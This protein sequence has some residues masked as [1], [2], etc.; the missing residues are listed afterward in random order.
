M[1]AFPL[2]LFSYSWFVPFTI[3]E[4]FSRFF[5]HFLSFPSA[6]SL[7]PSCFL[8]LPS[9]TFL[10]QVFFSFLPPPPHHLAASFIFLARAPRSEFKL[11][12]LQFSPS[13]PVPFIDW[14]YPLDWWK[15]NKRRTT[16]FRF[17]ANHI[18]PLSLIPAYIK[19]LDA[20][21]PNIKS[22]FSLIDFNSLCGVPCRPILLND[23][24][25]QFK[26]KKIMTTL[27]ILSF[28]SS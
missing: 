4:P 20:A 11:H 6:P 19:F 10:K 9:P 12:Q 15:R 3:L 22:A 28:I 27:E 1:R 25:L 26:N 23:R 17:L 8:L 18:K 21:M 2:C 16:N 5:Y 14:Q 24:G 7:P 13:S